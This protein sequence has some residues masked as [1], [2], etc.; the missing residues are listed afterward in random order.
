[1]INIKRRNAVV[2]IG[3]ICLLGLNSITVRASLNDKSD[4]PSESNQ[5]V[6]NCGKLEFTESIGY[7]SK[8]PTQSL[9]AL[10][11]G[12]CDDAAKHA[13]SYLD[14]R[15]LAK[16]R[17]VC[18]NF[19]TLANAVIDSHKR[20]ARGG[21]EGALR[22]CCLAYVQGHPDKEAET[23]AS[24]AFT[25][26]HE[27]A[28]L[29]LFD[30]FG[31]EGKNKITGYLKSQGLIPEGMSDGQDAVIEAVRETPAQYREAFV[32][33]C[34]ALMSEE[35]MGDR[36]EA[37]IRIVINTPAQYREAFVRDCQT[38]ISEK[39]DNNQIYFVIKAVS[40]APAQYREDLVKN[41]LALMLENMKAE[42][43]YD[44][45]KAVY[46]LLYAKVKMSCQSL[47]SEKVSDVQREAII[48]AVSEVP[49][50]YREDLVKY[51]QPFISEKKEADSLYDAIKAVYKWRS[52][53]RVH[54]LHK[55]N[56]CT[57]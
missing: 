42:Y 30:K 26:G 47:I 36:R 29:M 24:T 44:A 12:L 57:G 9:G 21:Y 18:R 43:I 37:V 33:N 55:Q 6:A 31:K 46:K 38:L 13:L 14:P 25:N 15:S 27:Y 34:L 11:G 39:M 41:C 48:R 32:R 22:W 53:L 23:I 2:V 17:A 40:E 7:S 54:S 50:Q 16:T 35:M 3:F 19:P 49:A 1:M 8:M 51:C 10:F 28:V 52:A 20:Y 56:S 45:I 5:H 4:E